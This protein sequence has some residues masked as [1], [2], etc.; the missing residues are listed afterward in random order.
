M[1]PWRG[2]RENQPPNITTARGIGREAQDDLERQPDDG[3]RY[4]ASSGSAGD[5]GETASRPVALA[6]WQARAS[7]MPVAALGKLSLPREERICDGASAAILPRRDQSAA[8]ASPAPVRPSSAPGTPEGPRRGASLFQRAPSRPPTSS[9]KHEREV[10][11][12]EP[13]RG[14][15]LKRRGE[16]TVE[17]GRIMGPETSDFSSRPPPPA[18]WRN[19]AKPSGR[20]GPIRGIVGRVSTGGGPAKPVPARYHSGC[21]CVRCAEAGGVGPAISCFI[22][23]P[24]TKGPARRVDA[25]V[26]CGT[27]CLGTTIPSWPRTRLRSS[28]PLEASGLKVW[29]T[30]AQ[31]LFGDLGTL[32][33]SAGPAERGSPPAMFPAAWHREE[34]RAS[35]FSIPESIDYRREARAALPI[36]C[37][38]LAM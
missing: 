32:P 27:P 30:R 26:T 34:S 4:S 37:L 31:W 25:D 33:V 1:L 16:N 2:G 5:P 15:C 6:I 14:A 3:Q 28:L 29:R 22:T 9:E 35:S 10:S 18:T 36:R 24:G 8:G 20:A 11:T 38:A 7:P 23:L 12:A 17:S 13:I 21:A 19:W